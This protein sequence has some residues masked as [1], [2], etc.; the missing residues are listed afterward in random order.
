MTR[1]VTLHTPPAHGRR[2]STR[3][4]RRPALLPGRRRRD[5]AVGCERLALAGREA[6]AHDRVRRVERTDR[7]HRVRPTSR[8]IASCQGG[9]TASAD[10]DTAPPDG[11]TAP[12]R[13]ASVRP[14]PATRHS[15]WIAQRS[16][17]RLAA[18]ARLRIE[19]AEIEPLAV[20]HRRRPV[21]VQHVPLVEHGSAIALDQ[22]AS[23][24]RESPPR[25]AAG[26]A[27]APAPR[28]ECRAPSCS[29][30]AGRTRRAEA[31]ARRCSGSTRSISSRQARHRQP[32]RAPPWSRRSGRPGA[33]RPRS[34]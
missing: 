26:C 27:R 20:L 13:R 32:E 30:T 28:S 15:V 24:I 10:R 2:R 31:G 7:V 16:A 12:S 25:R 8:S 14:S 33:A 1:T 22:S 21:G 6:E 34:S 19:H 5:L 29:G 18:A 17:P 4:R 23:L 11:E 9:A 3:S